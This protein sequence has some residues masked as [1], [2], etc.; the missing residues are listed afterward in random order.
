MTHSNNTWSGTGPMSQR[1]LSGPRQA[2]TIL[3]GA[4]KLNEDIG[5]TKPN[6]T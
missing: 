1:N 5:K 3:P 2:P 6:R 4:M